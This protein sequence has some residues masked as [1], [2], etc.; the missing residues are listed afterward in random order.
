MLLS[1]HRR[2]DPEAGFGLGARRAPLSPSLPGD[3]LTPGAPCP[4]PARA[5][6]C[7]E[8]PPPPE[9]VPWGEP[10][11]V[12]LPLPVRPR[13]GWRVCRVGRVAGRPVGAARFSPPCPLKRI[14]T[15][16]PLNRAMRPGSRLSPRP[17]SD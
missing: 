12:A 4:T 13:A 8:R 9:T 11:P 5:G 10:S 16:A 17:D 2:A 1:T 7:T 6:C 3:G 14:S 15:D